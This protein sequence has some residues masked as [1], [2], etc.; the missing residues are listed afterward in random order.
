MIVDKAEV[1]FRSGRGEEVER[2]VILLHPG[3]RIERLP[4]AETEGPAVM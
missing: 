3:A 4:A 1:Y 2:E